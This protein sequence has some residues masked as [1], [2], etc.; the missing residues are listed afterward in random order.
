MKENSVNKRNE[1]DITVNSEEK[2]YTV[3]EL[4]AALGVDKNTLNRWLAAL[5]IEPIQ[6]N[7]DS[8]RKYIP[9]EQAQE[10]A[11]AHGRKLVQIAEELPRTLAAAHKQ[12]IELIRE[13]ASLKEQIGQLRAQAYTYRPTIT[14]RAITREP[15]E[16]DFSMLTGNE[17]PLMKFIEAHQIAHSTALAAVSAGKIQIALSERTHAGKPI[18][19]ITAF[20]MS[21]FYRLYNNNEKFQSCPECPHTTSEPITSSSEAS[22]DAL[23]FDSDSDTE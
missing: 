19:L 12:I 8:R 2:G 10:V 23:G 14:P 11:L 3:A 13:N 17:V 9:I 1:G 16:I 15:R 7:Y 4:Q 5:N 20:G 22:Q 21:Q 6:D 18:K